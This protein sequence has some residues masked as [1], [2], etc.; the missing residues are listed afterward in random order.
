MRRVLA[1]VILVGLAG[2]A[3]YAAYAGWNRLSTWWTPAEEVDDWR[4]RELRFLKTAYDRLEAQLAKR[5]NTPGT[6]SLRGEQDVIR[7]RMIEAATSV[8]LET[9]P[10]EIRAL[11]GSMP[12]AAAAVAPA[13]SLPSPEPSREVSAPVAAPV[14]P[15]EAASPAP[16]HPI[17]LRAGRGAMP[18]PPAGAT[19]L[20]RDPALD[21][22]P[23]RSSS[24]SADKR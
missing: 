1:V 6:G 4:Q 16:A 19:E 18:E 22:K 7:Q 10:P 3:A 12:A 14:A 20:S 23:S 24:A 21:R 8:P 2:S 11:V 17:I 9:I 13:Q 15:T 5:P